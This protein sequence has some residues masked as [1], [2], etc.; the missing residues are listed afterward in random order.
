MPSGHG[1]AMTEQAMGMSQDVV[2]RQYVT[3][4]KGL[5]ATLSQKPQNA[6]RTPTQGTLAVLDVVDGARLWYVWGTLA[7]HDIRQRYRRSKIGPFWLTISMSVMIGAFG[8]LYAGLFRTDVVQYLPHV[9][10]GFVVW[11][12]VSG[13]T[14]D[15]CNAFIESQGSIKQVRLPLS[16]YVYRVVWRNLIIFCHNAL[17]VV[18]VLLVFAIRPGWIALLA[19]PAIAVLCLNGVWAGLLLGLLSARFRD[20]PQIVASALQ[21]VFFLTPIIWQPELLP[22]RALVLRFNPFFY[23]LELVRAPLL[24][25]MP[26]LLS[27]LVVL[28]ATGA[29]TAIALAMYARYRR[30]IA[31]WI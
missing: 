30:R 17:I 3:D 29:G 22:D 19:V 24:G 14:N 27:W 8:G 16:V 9:A 1:I 15:G 5:G 2:P 26:P 31:Y 12:F 6:Q 4:E 11:G 7:W 10:V 13:L 23:A 28:A 25:A 20:V 21:V 18:V